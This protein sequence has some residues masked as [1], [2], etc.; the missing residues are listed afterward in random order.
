LCFE[1]IAGAEHGDEFRH[2]GDSVVRPITPA[3]R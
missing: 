2:E 3:R 1:W